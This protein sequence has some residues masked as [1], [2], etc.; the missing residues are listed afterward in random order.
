MDVK[1][2]LKVILSGEHA[3]VYG[4]P[5]VA[6][7][8]DMWTEVNAEPHDTTVISTRY[9]GFEAGIR[10]KRTENG[11]WTV[12]SEDLLDE[13]SYLVEAVKEAERMGADPDANIEIKCEGPPGSG[14]GTSAS[15]IC[16]ILVALLGLSGVEPDRDEIRRAVRNVE[17]RVQ[18]RASWTDAT[19]VT[20]GGVV[21]VK[22]DNVEK[23]SEEIPGH[24]LVC[25]SGTPGPTARALSLVEGLREEIPA[26]VD[27]VME[28]IGNVAEGVLEAVIERDASKMGSLMN[29][30]HGLLSALGVSTRELDEIV[31]VA[32]NCGALGAKVT[33]AGTGGCAIAL[34]EDRRAAE[35]CATTLE[36]IG[37]E[38]WVV[39]TVSDGYRIS[40][41]GA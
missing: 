14:L 25:Y 40:G 39:R 29:V 17:K 11:G 33:G 7:A 2:P 21:K 37:Y 16:G 28:E 27:G 13:F 36:A 20:L 1:V 6:A 8:V 3:V 38:A 41:S 15:V 5:A 32:R 30:N 35:R 26:I 19:V 9:F 4:H 22:G 31:N 34:F 18:G 24:I 12:A 23:L 10:V